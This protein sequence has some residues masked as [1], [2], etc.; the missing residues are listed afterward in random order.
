MQNS[1]SSTRP[2]CHV[3]ETDQPCD[4][5]SQPFFRRP[6]FEIARSIGSRL[7]RIRP[8][9]RRLRLN[10]KRRAGATSGVQVVLDLLNFLAASALL[11]LP[12]FWNVHV[13]QE[14]KLS[15]LSL[16]LFI[17]IVLY[18]LVHRYVLAGRFKPRRFKLEEKKRPMRLAGAVSKFAVAVGERIRENAKQP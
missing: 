1:G 18:T 11:A 3:A 9:V 7:S 13:A 16:A 10:I 4:S 14:W 6:L 5:S 17:G 2:F 12:L 8:A 15:P